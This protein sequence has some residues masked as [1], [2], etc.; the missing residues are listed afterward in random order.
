MI[1][2]D[3]WRTARR[4][5]AIVFALFML[6][7]LTVI[8]VASFTNEGYVRFPPASFGLRW[9]K[10]ALENSYFTGG[11]V[12]SL[13]VATFVA[14]VSG[15]LGIAAA[16]VLARYRFHGREAI[17]SLLMMPIALPHIVLAIALLQVV[18]TISVPSSPYGLVAGH[19]LITL[20]YV[21]R[22]TMASLAGIDRQIETASASLG[23]SPWQTL[24]LVILPM[25]APGAVAGILFAFLI[26]FDEVTIS[27]FTALPDRTTLPAEIF[28]FASHGSDPIVTAVS[29]VMILFAAILVIVVERFFGVLRLIANEDRP[30]E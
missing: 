22:L 21:L 15:V 29:G 20:P 27:L 1:G 4:I 9:Y 16:L 10:A 17:V 28:G 2:S 5:F 30:I 8:M 11:F 26:S 6:M 19:L 3:F 12:F 7:P 24:R 14:I 18:A 25:I 13:E 23:A